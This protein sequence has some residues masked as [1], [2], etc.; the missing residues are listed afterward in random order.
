M[1]NDTRTKLNYILKEFEKNEE[2]QKVKV[3]SAIGLN[4]RAFRN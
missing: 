1:Q 3:K 2:R 4:Q